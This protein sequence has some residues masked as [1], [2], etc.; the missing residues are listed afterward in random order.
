MNT[1]LHRKLNNEFSYQIIFWIALFSFGLARNYGEHDNPDFAAL[2]YYDVCHWIF[3]I[4]GANFIYFI[5]IRKYFDSK[6]YI[7]FFIHLFLSLYILGVFN[8]IFIIYAAEPFFTDEPKDSIIDIFSDVRYLLFHYIITIISGAFIFISIMFILRYK[9]EKH[10]RL[11][12][13]KE[14]TELE[15]KVLK[16]QLNPHFLFNTLNNI[17]SLSV[18]NSSATA[19]SI[20]RLSDILDYILRKGQNKWVNVAEEMKI[21]DDYIELEKLRYNER[22]KI[23]IFKNIRYSAVIP[24]LLYLSLVE[25]AFKHSEKISG[26]VEINIF[27]ETDLNFI[28]F[29]VE[30]HFS[31]NISDN[32]TAGIGLKNINKQLELYYTD[33]Y[34][35]EIEK[36]ENWFSV[37]VTTPLR[38]D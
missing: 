7:P 19:Q 16:S 23:N 25:N 32:G 21:I 26:N 27:L 34:S 28:I 3:Q 17:Y 20:S 8:R 36:P 10:N 1:V 31:K 9:N 11:Q 5:L 2:F 37:K 30:N 14:K 38:Y 6:K 24:P 4:I 18:S 13:E 15:L 33:A 29:K 35:L 12:L 22:L